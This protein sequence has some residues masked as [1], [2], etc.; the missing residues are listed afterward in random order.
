MQNQCEE[1][2][3]GRD[4]KFLESGLAQFLES[5][6]KPF[7]EE[8]GNHLGTLRQLV[9]DPLLHIFLQRKDENHVNMSRLV[10]NN[11]VIFITNTF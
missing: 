5:L 8:N 1:T 3:I 9:Q 7:L 6:E 11:T 10:G 2:L 4:I